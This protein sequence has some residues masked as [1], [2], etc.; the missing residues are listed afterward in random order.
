M[1]SQSIFMTPIITYTPIN[2]SILKQS[3]GFLG[4]TKHNVNPLSLEPV[5]IHVSVRKKCSND[6]M[7]NPT[8]G[9][10]LKNNNNEN[11]SPS[12]KKKNLLWEHSI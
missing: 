5:F 3:K 9:C 7:F 11:C 8:K 1:L 10:M 4:K 2:F 12:N 6:F